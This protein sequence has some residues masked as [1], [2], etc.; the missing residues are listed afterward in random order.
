MMEIQNEK[1][2]IAG[3]LTVSEF[4]HRVRR[5]AKTAHNWINKGL[6]GS[7]ERVVTIQGRI[8]IH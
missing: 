1:P 2:K 6:I 5:T 3:H 4:S 7:Q 8:L